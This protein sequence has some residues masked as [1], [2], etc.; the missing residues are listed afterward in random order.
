MSAA[1]NQRQQ[2]GTKEAN[3]ALQNAQAAAA[4]ELL[5]VNC[6]QFC[7]AKIYYHIQETIHD[8]TFIHKYYFSC[9]PPPKIQFME[10]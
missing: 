4:S 9:L 3:I 2:N 1:G 8:C 7:S 5:Q 10:D 6:S